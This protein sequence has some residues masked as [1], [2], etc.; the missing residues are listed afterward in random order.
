VILCRVTGDLVSTVRS[1]RLPRER[2]LLCQ[3]VE[4]DGRT[5]RGNSFVALDSLHTCGASDLVLAIREGSGAR[6]IYGDEKIPAEA[7]IVAMV[8]ELTVAD[9]KKL[10]GTSSLEMVRAAEAGGEA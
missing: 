9:E 5:A 8:D 7:V 4:L 1:A 6:L 2:L 3:P 10:M